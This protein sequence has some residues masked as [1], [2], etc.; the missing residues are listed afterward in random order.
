MG[1]DCFG[2][3]NFPICSWVCLY[4]ICVAGGFAYYLLEAL[5]IVD[6]TEEFLGLFRLTTRKSVNFIKDF[7]G[8]YKEFFGTF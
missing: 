2:Y 4:L 8:A 7:L 5:I 1:E 6:S 3:P